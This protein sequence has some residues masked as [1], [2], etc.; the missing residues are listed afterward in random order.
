M[1]KN[2]NYQMLFK[3]LKAA[4]PAKCK[5][6]LQD[7]LIKFWNSNK[8]QDNFEEII[9]NKCLELSK[10]IKKK[11]AGLLKFWANVSFIK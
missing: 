1:D 7:E 5:K 10:I 6:L 8:S 11:S 2:K 3:K 9:Q 4:Y